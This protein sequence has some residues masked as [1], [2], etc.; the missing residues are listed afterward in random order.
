MNIDRKTALL[1]TLV[2]GG[3]SGVATVADRSSAGCG[4]RTRRGADVAVVSG[5]NTQRFDATRDRHRGTP[6]DRGDGSAAWVTLTLAQIARI[7]TK[8]CGGSTSMS[9]FWSASNRG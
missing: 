1:S 6:A 2:T 3:D 7:L 5:W 4:C 9:P 8:T